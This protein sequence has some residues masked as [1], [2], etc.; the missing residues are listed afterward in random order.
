MIA[1]ETT[2]IEVV[3]TGFEEL[4]AQA[5]REHGFMYGL[6]TALLALGTGLLANFIFRRD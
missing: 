4:F 1:R 5:A 6:A 2:A 3:K